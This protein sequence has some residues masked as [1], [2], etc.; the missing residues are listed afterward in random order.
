MA[1][2]LSDAAPRVETSSRQRSST[3]ASCDSSASPASSSSLQQQQQQQQ[4]QVLPRARRRTLGQEDDDLAAERRRSSL[5]SRTE[6]TPVPAIP[7][8]FLHTRNSSLPHP[9]SHAA[10]SP[11]ATPSTPNTTPNARNHAYN[12]DSRGAP[13]SSPLAHDFD[14]SFT[15]DTPL[16][17]L[18]Q[19][20]AVQQTPR[21]ASYYN[22]SRRPAPRHAVAVANFSTPRPTSILPAQTSSHTRA[23]SLPTTTLTGK[24]RPSKDEA[25]LEALTAQY[26]GMD[27]THPEA[28]AD[29]FLQLAE[30]ANSS[31]G[32]PTLTQRAP[33]RAT[34]NDKRQQSISSSPR[35]SVEN[36]RPR[37]AGH[38]TGRPSSR[39]STH[40][41]TNRANTG[42][43]TPGPAST[44]NFTSPRYDQTTPSSAHL[45]R[46]T[47][48]SNAPDCSPRSATQHYERTQSPE[49]SPELPTFGRR[50]PSFGYPPSTSRNKRHSGIS[51][52]P[53]GSDGESPATSSETK[54]SAAESDSADSQTAP[55]TVWDELDD[56]KSRIKKLELTGK[57]PSTSNAAVT[58]GGASSDRPRTATTAPTTINSSPKQDRKQDQDAA[59]GAQ[60]SKPPTPT[61]LTLADIHPTL[62]VA[63][64]KAK[65][66]LS[67][68]LY[69]SLEATAMDAL[70]LV[71][72][73][74]SAGPQGTT[75]SAASIINGVT[76]SDR[77]IR[78]KADM[79]CRNLTDL[80]LALC[81]GKH[82]APSIMSS[83]VAIDTPPK[84]SGPKPKY[85]RAS[86]A[87]GEDLNKAASRPLSR[88][89]ARRSS[90]LGLQPMSS[91]QSSGDDISVSEHETTP[92]HSHRV[93][94]L[95]RQSRLGNRLSAPRFD[96]YEDPS[97][98][99]DI[100]PP[101]R[102]MTEFGNFRSPHQQQ[103]PRDYN[104]TTA[105]LPHRSPSLRESLNARRANGTSHVSNRELPRVASLSLDP[106]RRRF[107]RDSTP[108]VLE[109]V[110]GEQVDL[111]YQ[112]R[113]LTSFGHY[114]SSRRAVDLSASRSTSLNHRHANVM[115]E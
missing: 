20:Q 38:S 21:G 88:L 29:L 57:I 42:Y 48:F 24:R 64:A 19:A 11:A 4:Q 107:P 45:R 91:P 8:H 40:I 75:F 77:H 90:I 82:E 27:Q 92:S 110:P 99:E 114:V 113:R 111:A 6:P 37:A 30:D 46:K 87:F 72:M 68:T 2:R 115:V 71:A 3:L 5:I 55:S 78:R 66:L 53:Q 47:P 65:A 26:A 33:S 81:E 14:F 60:N 101:S 23:G 109:E 67:A 69:R 28:N 35:T 94:E 112:R 76:V 100:R 70:Q 18:S 106:S 34:W 56:L 36:G 9:R 49:K 52:K 89:E 17:A 79:M 43:R 51:A 7:K 93:P 83:P 63:L 44:T 95:H 62:H 80:C 103:S 58:G 31:D 86:M 97:G 41:D 13:A 32:E 85:S 15:V 22:S 104:T 16:R 108:P 84:I 1:T 50:R 39:F 73:T 61:S 54:Q 59:A 102:A 10:P 74:G 96:R 12:R 25:T 98:D 105:K